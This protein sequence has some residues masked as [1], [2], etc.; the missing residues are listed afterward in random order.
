MR[1]AATILVL[2]GIWALL[3]AGCAGDGDDQGVAAAPATEAAETTS[4]T[5]SGGDRRAGGAGDA[6]TDDVRILGFAFAPATVRAKVGQ[7]VKWEH[8]DPGV[9]HT[10]VALDGSFRSGRLEEGD[11]FSHLF[12][13]AG[14]FAYRCSLHANMRGRVKVGG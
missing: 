14:T 13:R 9:T 5:G 3:A 1:R 2:V 12:T 7:K 11:E 8:Q 10:V 4:T 6:D